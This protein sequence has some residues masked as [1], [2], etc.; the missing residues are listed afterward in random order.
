MDL[1]QIRLQV[2]VQRA[3]EQPS[4][5]ETI[6]AKACNEPRM[7]KNSDSISLDASGDPRPAATSNAEVS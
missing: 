6:M 7:L 2:R 3:S 1:Q 4:V 5:N